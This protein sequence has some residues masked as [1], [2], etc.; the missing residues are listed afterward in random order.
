M[1]TVACCGGV[2][3]LLLLFVFVVGGSSLLFFTYLPYRAA[4]N[5]L[6]RSGKL[7][8][9][10]FTLFGLSFL[11]SLLWLGGTALGTMALVELDRNAGVAVPL[12]VALALMGAIG[13]RVLLIAWLTS[14]KPR[15]RKVETPVP[16]LQVWF[17][18]LL[19]AILCYGAGLTIAATF[20]DFN[21]K[22]AD[23]FLPIAIYLLAIGTFGG[24]VSLDIARRSPWGKDP[25]KRA[26][27]FILIFSIFPLTAPLALIAYWRWR[28]ALRL[29][30]A[31]EVTS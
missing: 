7:S 20:A 1:M 5:S 30:P 18:D 29:M 25:L 13:W 15:N 24:F 3:I 26:L 12:I 27:M 2:D 8:G 6:G 28:R 31:P 14:K 23:E 16:P 22:R 10:P 17:Q 19:V 21:P 9:Q 11:G 4:M